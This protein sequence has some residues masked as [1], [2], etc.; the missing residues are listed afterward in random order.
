MLPL[1]DP[2]LRALASGECVVA[3]VPRGSVDEGD[4]VQLTGT[5]RLAPQ[6]LKPAYR[7][8][9]DIGPPPGTWTAVV[10]AVEPAAILDPVAGAARHILTE[11]GDGDVVVLHV[12]GADGPVLDDD[13]YAA[14]RR[15]V[16]GALT[17]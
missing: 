3:F 9:A 15:S 16:T 11:P 4:E 2:E 14:R 8:W 5:A 12:Y 17:Q 13:A 7:R 10:D 1:S 6:A